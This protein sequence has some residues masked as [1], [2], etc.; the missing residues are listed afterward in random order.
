[1]LKTGTIIEF[2]LVVSKKTFLKSK[3]QV[4][5]LLLLFLL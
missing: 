5:H 3:Q 1:L 4:G 2:G